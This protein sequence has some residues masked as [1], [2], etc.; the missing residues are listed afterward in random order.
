VRETHNF[1]IFSNTQRTHSNFISWV[2]KNS[3]EISVLHNHS[4]IS[5]KAAKN[6]NPSQKP[7]HFKN[8][9]ENTTDQV[10]RLDMY[11]PRQQHNIK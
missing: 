6:Q 4:K 8:I 1:I 3:S 7:S 9:L 2:R 5:S 11:A 10:L